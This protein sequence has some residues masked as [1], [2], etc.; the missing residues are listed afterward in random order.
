MTE[1]EFNTAPTMSPGFE[2]AQLRVAVDDERLAAALRRV[3][4]HLFVPDYRRMMAYHDVEISLGQGRRCPQPSAIVQLLSAANLDGPAVACVWAG[5]GYMVALLAAMGLDVH[6]VESPGTLRDMA[7]QGLATL[8]LQDRVTWHDDI[9]S[10]AAESV[11]SAV[12]CAG[13]PRFPRRLLTKVPQHGRLVVPILRGHSAVVSVITRLTHGHR[14][15]DRPSVALHSLDGI[16]AR[17]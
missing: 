3:T 12:V 11:Q 9:E 16:P 6:A 5:S 14:R 2:P 4:R 1:S 13:V 8:N 15:Q 10:L 17:R 7:I